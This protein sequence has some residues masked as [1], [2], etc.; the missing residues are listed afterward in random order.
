MKKIRIFY[1]K[2]IKLHDVIIITKEKKNY[3]YLKNV[4][5]IKNTDNVE[6]FNNT[7]YIF[8]CKINILEKKIELIIHSKK[9]FNNESPIYIH[10]AQII[11][12]KIK[13]IDF[14]IQKSTELGVNEITPIYFKK[15]NNQLDSF[16]KKNRRWKEIIISSCLQSERMRIPIL[17]KPIEFEKWCEFIK[18]I[19][20]A[21]VV[22]SP[23]ASL[24]IKDLK[25]NINK[26]V[27]L[28]GPENG[29]EENIE[30]I[31]SFGFIKLNLG[32]RILKTDTASITAI[33]N[34]QSQYG[35]I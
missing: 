26:I 32:P 15:K 23:N 22:F 10:Y 12:K 24:K 4:L 19:K 21:K 33:S 18:N 35:D 34:I 28:I 30:K 29:L 14:S 3:H 31:V 25:K 27:F 2:M 16:I 8:Y 6:I 17:N 1:T 5:R 7:K 13:K 20:C 11:P 9:K